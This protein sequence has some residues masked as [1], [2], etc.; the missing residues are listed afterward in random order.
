MIN[1]IAQRQHARNYYWKNLERSRAMA[2]AR[3]KKLRQSKDYRAKHRLYWRKW[4]RLRRLTNPQHA[5]RRS[6][7]ARLREGLKA[8]GATK[9]G[10]TVD[11]LGCSYQQF[12]QWLELQFTDGM[13]WDNYGT[14]WVVDHVVPIALFDLTDP[15][16]AK[17][18]FHFTN[19]QPM[20]KAANNAK[21]DRLEFVN[22]SAFTTVQRDIREVQTLL[23]IIINQT[24]QHD[25]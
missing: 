11:L 21:G 14:H 12:R 20:P 15:T 2:A 13:T 17:V 7:R 3:M 25:N 4:D 18:A 6:Y 23:Q 24:E 9:T 8:A 10:S 1:R 19:T 22:L 5:L 16:H